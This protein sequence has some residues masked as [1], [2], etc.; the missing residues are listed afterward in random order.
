LLAAARGNRSRLGREEI[1][2]RVPLRREGPIL[3]WVPFPGRARWYARGGDRSDACLRHRRGRRSL[4]RRRGSHWRRLGSRRYRF[5][6]LRRRDPAI[7]RQAPIS[8]TATRKSKRPC[9]PIVSSRPRILF[10]RGTLFVF[11]ADSQP[12]K[13]RP[14]PGPPGQQPEN[15]FGAADSSLRPAPRAR[16]AHFP[17]PARTISLSGLSGQPVFASLPS[18]PLPRNP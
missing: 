10:L 17:P 7:N 18:L 14:S 16:I 15:P 8:T 4:H 6:L 13:S 9:M 11:S 12:D 2:L 1:T 5:L 3:P